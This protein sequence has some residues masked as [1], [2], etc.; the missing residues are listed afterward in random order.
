MTNMFMHLHSSLNNHTRFQTKMGK[1][2]PKQQKTTSFRQA[3]VYMD[4]Y[5]LG[6]GVPLGYQLFLKANLSSTI[7]ANDYRECIRHDF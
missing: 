1:V 4:P 3:H 2:R 5:G 7:F 6:K